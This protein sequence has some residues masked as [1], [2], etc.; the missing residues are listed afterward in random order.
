MTSYAEKTI[1][2]RKQIHFWLLFCILRC[3]E[4]FLL[5]TI[6]VLSEVL[7]VN[8]SIY[9]LTVLLPPAN[10][11]AGRQGFHRCLYTYSRDG[12]LLSLPW[13]GY[14]WSRVPSRVDGYAQ[15]VGMVSPPPSPPA[16]DTQGRSPHILSASGWYASNWNA[17]LFLLCW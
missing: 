11:V 5:P 17:F 14:A 8:E 3:V 4:T 16:D 10:E 9:L 6:T 15:R 12:Y 2:K 13:G 1:Y 7:Y